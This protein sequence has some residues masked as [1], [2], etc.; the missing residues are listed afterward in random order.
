MIMLMN[1]NDNKNNNYKS[2]VKHRNTL[3]YLDQY[4]CTGLRLWNS[5]DREAV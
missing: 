1:D 4:T 2:D 3:G 5:R